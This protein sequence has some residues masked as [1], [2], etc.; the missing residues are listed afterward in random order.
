MRVIF[1][2]EWGTTTLIRLNYIFIIAFQFTSFIGTKA[3]ISFIYV[4]ANLLS[5]PVINHPLAGDND[6]V[7]DGWGLIVVTIE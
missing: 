6:N 2:F 4:H 7:E 1:V 3:Y 5:A